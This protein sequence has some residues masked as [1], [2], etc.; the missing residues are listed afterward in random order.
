VNRPPLALATLGEPGAHGFCQA[1]GLDAETRFEEAFGNREC[2]IKLGLAGEVA[3]AKIVKPIERTGTALG[4]YNDFHA[5]LL[6][7]H[8]A[9]ITCRPQIKVCRTKFLAAAE[10]AN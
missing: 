7:V 4:P 9:S 5:Q 6:S 1:L 2:V 3:H 8:K 10:S